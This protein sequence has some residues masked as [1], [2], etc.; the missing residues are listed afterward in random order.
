MG[1][2]A[3][4]YRAYTQRD[5]PGSEPGAKCDVCD[6]LVVVIWPIALINKLTLCRAPSVL[7]WV[8][9]VTM[10]L[11]PTQLPTLSGMGNKHRTKCDDALR[12]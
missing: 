5:S 2:M 8:I 11:S 7:K 1:H 10:P 12:L 3:R 6:C 4:G 9:V